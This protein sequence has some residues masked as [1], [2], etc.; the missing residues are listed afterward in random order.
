MT[1][2]QQRIATVAFL[3][4]GMGGATALILKAFNQNLMYF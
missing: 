3:L 1:R 4:L 2:R